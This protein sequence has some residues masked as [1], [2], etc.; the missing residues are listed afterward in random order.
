MTA[1]VKGLEFL[2][3]YA[4]AKRRSKNRPNRFNEIDLN[5]L[6]VGKGENVREEND[7]IHRICMAFP[8]ESREVILESLL[9][10]DA[11]DLVKVEEALVRY[12]DQLGSVA[13]DIHGLARCVDGPDYHRQTFVPRVVEVEVRR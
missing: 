11:S 6:S 1:W 5:P 10:L 3:R 7:R 4:V 8:R 2:K 13:H 12:P 9:E